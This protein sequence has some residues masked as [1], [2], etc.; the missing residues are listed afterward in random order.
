MNSDINENHP[1]VVLDT[2]VLI[3]AIGFGGNPRTIL[4]LTI[5]EKI[6]GITSRV[7]LAELH[8]VISKKFSKLEPQL[9]I[10][11]RQIEEKFIIVQP[12]K[13]INLVRDEDDNRVLEAALEGGCDYIISGDEDLLNL[14]QFKNIKIITPDEFLKEID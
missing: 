13:S 10:I 11:E 9:L 8:E 4:L 2:N 6:K 14:G 1:K 5:E 12:K 7:L 3:S